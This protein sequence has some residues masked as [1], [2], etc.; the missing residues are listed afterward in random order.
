MLTRSPLRASG[1]SP[2]C[3]NAAAPQEAWLVQRGTLAVS[4]GSVESLMSSRPYDP[5]HHC[6]HPGRLSPFV[7]TPDGPRQ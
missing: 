7:T 6:G 4:L 5:L 2:A 1:R 3:G